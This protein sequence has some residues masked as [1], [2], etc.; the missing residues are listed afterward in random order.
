MDFYRIHASVRAL[1]TSRCS[2]HGRT[3]HR[4]SLR[5]EEI[6]ACVCV[7]VCV[8]VFVCYRV[9]ARARVCVFVC[10][11]VCV[12]VCVRVSVH[13]CVYVY[14]LWC[15]ELRFAWHNIDIGTGDSR[16]V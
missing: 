9:R 12:C 13:L 2:T 15:T 14:V 5:E 1:G 3:A 4:L 7:C 6:D 8:F 10:D 11:C 16:K